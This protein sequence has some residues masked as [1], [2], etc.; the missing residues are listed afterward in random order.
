MVVT[1]LETQIGF[2]LNALCCALCRQPSIDGDQLMRDFAEIIQKISPQD[3]QS[4]VVAKCALDLMDAEM[5][6]IR[7]SKQMRP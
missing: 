4:L 6:R 5:Q 3:P 2:S 1:P 7:I